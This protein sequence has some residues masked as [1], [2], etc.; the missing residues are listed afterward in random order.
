MW[1]SWPRQD[2][3]PTAPTRQGQDLGGQPTPDKI[4]DEG[5]H[6]RLMPGDGH[7]NIGLLSMKLGRGVV[8]VCY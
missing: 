8:E 4:A 2:L 6:H 7:R 1:P 3:G 5:V